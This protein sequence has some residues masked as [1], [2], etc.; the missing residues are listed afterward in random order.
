MKHAIEKCR[1]VSPSLS[2][3]AHTPHMGLVWRLA[4]VIRHVRQSRLAL[5]FMFIPSSSNT[6][7]YLNRLLLF[8]GGGVGVW[9]TTLSTPCCFGQRLYL[10][11]GIGVWYGMV[12]YGMVWYGCMPIYMAHTHGRSGHFVSLWR[13]TA[14]VVVEILYMQ[15][16]YVRT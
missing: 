12:W 14:V 3:T 5:G 7:G 6:E 15:V 13:A 2:H 10:Q 8:C 1:I 4:D 16:P 9:V 11:F